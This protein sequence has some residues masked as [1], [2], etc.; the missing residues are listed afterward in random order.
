MPTPEYLLAMKCMAG[1][2]AEGATDLP[3]F[4]PGIYL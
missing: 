3:D 2:T 1:R 4:V